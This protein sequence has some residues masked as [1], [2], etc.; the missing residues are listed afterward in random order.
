[1][2]TKT[3]G[4]PPSPT[5]VVRFPRRQWVTLDGQLFISSIATAELV[6]DLPSPL[7]GPDVFR[8]TTVPAARVAQLVRAGRLWV[9]TAGRSVDFS[10]AIRPVLAEDGDNANKKKGLAPVRAA[11]SAVVIKPW[12]QVKLR[13]AAV[14][15]LTIGPK[16]PS[17]LLALRSNSQEGEDDWAQPKHR[18][19]GTDSVLLSLVNQPTTASAANGLYAPR[20]AIPQAR[21]RRVA[22]QLELGGLPKDIRKLSDRRSNTKSK[23]QNR[24]RSSQRPPSKDQ[25]PTPLNQALFRNKD[26]WHKTKALLEV[27]LGSIMGGGHRV[28]GVRPIATTPRD[29]TGASL[30]NVAPAVWS[31]SYFQVWQA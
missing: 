7:S 27:S 9:G 26:V 24:D 29:N 14:A 6:W 31:P 18:R 19:H 13:K 10:L 1:M 11:V 22:C 3:S 28:H 16:G 12:L 21:F 5:T 23:R 20:G 30:V 8:S 15:T 2:A 25:G 17:E 4:L